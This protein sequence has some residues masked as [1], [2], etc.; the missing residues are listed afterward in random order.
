MKV[1]FWE[2][3]NRKNLSLIIT[4]HIFVSKIKFHNDQLEESLIELEKSILISIYESH[5]LRG[6][7][8][9]KGME[10]EALKDFIKAEELDPLSLKSILR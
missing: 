9:Q 2:Y 5:M 6:K 4:K 7:I 3:Q 1:H 8:N 10:Q